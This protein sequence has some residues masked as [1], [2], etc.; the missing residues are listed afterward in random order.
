LA[1]AKGFDVFVSDAGSIS[2]KHKEKLK[3]SGISYEEGKHTESAILKADEVMK[4]PGIPEKAAIVKKIREAQINLISEIEFASRYTDAF[5]VGI[6]GSNGKTTTTS[7]TGALLKHAGLNVGVGGNIGR[8]FASLVLEGDYEYIVLEISSFQLDD[9]QAFRPDIGVLMNITPDHLDRYNYRMEE[10]VASKFRITE[11]QTASDQFIYCADDPVTIQNLNNYPTAARQLPF[12]LETSEGM[13]AWLDGETIKISV[14]QNPFEMSIYELG[15][16]GKHNYYNSMA[17]GIVGSALNLRKEAIRES[18]S[19]FESLPHR[20]EKVATIRDV[21]YINDSKATNVNSTWYALETMNK[22]VVWIAGGVDKGNDYEQLIPLIRKKVKAIVCLG[23]DNRH[24][25]A[26]FSRTVDIMVN[27]TRMD[28]AV[29]VAQRLSEKGDAVLLSPA[30][31]SFDLFENY[32]DRG[33]Q[34]T[35]VVKSL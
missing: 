22:P 21:D 32:E 34:F 7:L 35:K 4:S 26:A 20:L 5:I 28:E 18:L 24:L 31:A 10:Y 19:H 25:H 3:A 17:A 14:D 6:T 23:V 8:S 13:A 11:N 9:I 27:T 29:K 1:Q 12:S 15:L 16:Q 33:D 30:C 2:P